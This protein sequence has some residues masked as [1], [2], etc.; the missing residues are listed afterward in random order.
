MTGMQG[1]NVESGILPRPPMSNYQRVLNSGLEPKRIYSFQEAIDHANL[2]SERVKRDQ[3]ISNFII[4]MLS[5]I[6]LIL[7]IVFLVLVMAGVI[8]FC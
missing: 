7:V 3:R 4:Y 8:C 1:N 5:A 2:L 6:L